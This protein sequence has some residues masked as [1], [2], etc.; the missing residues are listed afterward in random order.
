MLTDSD[1]P[2]VS[3]LIVAVT[4]TITL[5]LV[6]E[7]GLRIFKV[8]ND[9]SNLS[10]FQIVAIATAGSIINGYVFAYVVNGLDTSQ[11]SGGLFHSGFMGVIGNFAGNAIFVC[12]AVVIVRQQKR[13]K[14]F[15]AHLN[16]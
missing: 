13:I 9:L 8:E 3:W 5:Y 2:W 15:I 6:V 7:L 14:Q 4:V 10:Y 16:R 12:V 11:M 1:Q